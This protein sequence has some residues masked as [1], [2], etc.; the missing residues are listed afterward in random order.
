METAVVV[1]VPEANTQPLVVVPSTE[2][3]SSIEAPLGRLAT[4]NFAV[5]SFPLF[6]TDEEEGQ[7][8][9]RIDEQLL[10]CR[11]SATTTNDADDFSNE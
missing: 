1:V 5:A 6:V 8:R 9:R 10:F 3:L 4:R 2:W 7:G 11:R